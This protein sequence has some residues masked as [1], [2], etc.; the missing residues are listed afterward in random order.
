MEKLFTL[1]ELARALDV[2]QT[3]VRAW[4]RDG[5]I[6]QPEFTVGQAKAYTAECFEEVRDIIMKWREQRAKTEKEKAR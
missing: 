5:I 1:S 6:P 2:S 4:I 3:S